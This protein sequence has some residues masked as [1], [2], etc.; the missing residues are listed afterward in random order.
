MKTWIAGLILAAAI[1]APAHADGGLTDEQVT[2]ALAAAGFSPETGSEDTGTYWTGMITTPGG[3]EIAFYLRPYDCSEAPKRC[4][5]FNIF[6]N[7]GLDDEV[8]D[9]Q[10][11]R[12][13][14]YNDTYMRGR[15]FARPKEVGVD[16]V[17][18]VDGDLGPSYFERRIGEFPEIVGDFIDTMN[19]DADE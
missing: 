12:V 5:M 10:M 2:G 9:E 4:N 19:G 3:S 1:A 13:N 11:T 7:F 15:A 8:S 18:I 6:A 17:V 16:Y 14:S